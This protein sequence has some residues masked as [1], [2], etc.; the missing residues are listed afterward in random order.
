[1]HSGIAYQYAEGGAGRG[2]HCGYSP[3]AGVAAGECSTAA[4]GAAEERSSTGLAF[5]TF[6]SLKVDLPSSPPAKMA[7]PP[8]APPPRSRTE[9]VM[10]SLGSP[11]RASGQRHISTWDETP[12]SE[13]PPAK[14]TTP[15]SCV[16]P[17]PSE[18]PCKRVWQVTSSCQPRTR[19][20]PWYPPTAV[21]PARRR[22]HP[23]P[24]TDRPRHRHSRRRPGSSRR[25]W[26]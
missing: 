3:A 6:T 8:Q 19:P 23:S 16:S 1:M 25:C 4:G 21:V 5:Q 22:A 14:S 12:E 7:I 11:R 18:Q 10:P 15:A 13:Y 24:P 17:P 2:G 26:R 9:C 20:P